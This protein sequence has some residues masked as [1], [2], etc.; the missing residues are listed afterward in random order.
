[1]K[2]FLMILAAFSISISCTNES[3]KKKKIKIV[4]ARQGGNAKRD[5]FAIPVGQTQAFYKKLH[6]GTQSTIDSLI[7]DGQKPEK[8]LY[9]K[10]KELETKYIKSFPKKELAI[11]NKSKGNDLAPPPPSHVC[12]GNK[13]VHIQESLTEGTRMQFYTRL[14]DRKGKILTMENIGEPVLVERDTT[15]RL[16][17]DQAPGGS[18]A[19]KNLL[20]TDETGIFIQTVAKVTLEDF[21]G[22][23]VKAVLGKE[24]YAGRVASL[25]SQEEHK[26]QLGIRLLP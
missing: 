4:K 5:K 12:T 7:A 13:P 18:T 1:M 8:L 24:R 20:I 26:W 15:V 19:K 6:I 17:V 16:R 11:S 10:L 3:D 9:S 22:S 25:V 21:E 23:C 14:L 2:F